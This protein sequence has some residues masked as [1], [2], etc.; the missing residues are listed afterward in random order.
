MEG[1]EEVSTI[2]FELE[3]YGDGTRLHLNHH[4][5]TRPEEVDQNEAGW[6][7]QLDRLEALLA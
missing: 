5:F 1:D 3:P 6:S 7:H 4:G 2:V